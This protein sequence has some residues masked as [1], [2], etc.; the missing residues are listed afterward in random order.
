MQPKWLLEE[1]VFEEDLTPFFE[2]IAKQGMEVSMISYSMD[3][4]VFLNLWDPGDCVIVHGSFQ[5]IQRVKEKAAWIPGV[6]FNLPRF[7]CT[8]YYPRFGKH[9]L[10]EDYA[11]LPFGEL[12]RRK[13]FLA[14]TFGY[15]DC[16]FVR[17]DSG[18][19]TFSGKVAQLNDWEKEVER[20]GFYDVQPEE[21][22]LVSRPQFGLQKEWRLV[23]A[24]SKVISAS[25]Y[26]ANEKYDV[27]PDVPQDVT[28]FGQR[29]LDDVSYHPDHVWTMDI[30]ET[31]EG[32]L[33]VLEVGSFSGASLY[34]APKEPIV[35]EVSLIALEEWDSYQ[36]WSEKNGTSQS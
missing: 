29:V 20:F 5:L 25:Q 31:S 10:N 12:L 35:R 14:D 6:Y 16:V 3:D 15:L 28:D 7:K 2:E 27:T 22:V 13:E 11:M 4:S 19:K 36:E 21:L 34:V 30:C 32:D 33:R 8:Y 17:P 23:V 26:K 9:L 1:D 18:F 24:D